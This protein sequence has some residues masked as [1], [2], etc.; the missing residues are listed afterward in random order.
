MTPHLIVCPIDLSAEARPVLARAVALA[1]WHDAELHVAFVR[2]DGD[3]RHA[4]R[5]A[6]VLLSSDLDD[7]TVMPVVLEGDPVHAVVEYARAKSPDLVVV[8]QFGRRGTTH[9]CAGTYA[10][11]VGEAIQCP[12]IM[13]PADPSYAG[14]DAAFRNLVCGVDF[15]PATTE[16]VETALTIAQQGNGHM[17]LLHVMKRLP[18]GRAAFAPEDYARHVRAIERELGALV[19]AEAL[20]W[21]DVDALAVSGVPSD[22][23][24]ACASERRAD[25]I[26]LGRTRGIRQMGA[27]STLRGVLRRTHCPVLTVPER[28]GAGLPDARR[29]DGAR[30][31]ADGHSGL[32]V[33]TAV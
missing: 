31:A 17:T 3:D 19:P 29:A 26:V 23:I 24:L 27:R 7:V 21:C 5:F 18:Y 14:R 15:S 30:S 1:R 28:M 10:A 25:L 20:N 22:A 4:S 32:A 8:G 2:P 6:D 12:T 11:A 9:W 33:L 13:L 16:A